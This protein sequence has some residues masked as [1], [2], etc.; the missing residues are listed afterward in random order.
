MADMVNSASAPMYSGL[1]SEQFE[2][3]MAALDRAAPVQPPPAAIPLA[4]ANTAA[5]DYGAANTAPTP[6]AS[7]TALGADVGS[8]TGG[9]GGGNPADQPTT[10]ANPAPAQPAQ[11][12]PA[13]P[14]TS[15]SPASPRPPVSSGRTAP[16]HAPAPTH[17]AV[18][19]PRRHR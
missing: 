1:P 12:T 11:T 19:P 17:R 5:Y 13:K 16:K 6:A 7:M 3:I 15:P 8:F 2:A 9:T 4:A 14:T 18:H 10:D